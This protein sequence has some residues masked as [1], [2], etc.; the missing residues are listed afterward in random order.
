MR[1]MLMSV[2]I[3][4]SSL[5]M[6]GCGEAEP[7]PAPAAAGAAGS[8]GQPAKAGGKYEKGAAQ[9]KSER[10]TNSADR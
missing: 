1:R 3:L 2:V 7:T 8:T 9:E 5:A 6:M 10:K 4:G